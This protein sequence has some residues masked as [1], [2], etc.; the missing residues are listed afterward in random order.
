MSLTKVDCDYCQHS[1]Q[2]VGGEAVYP[3]RPDLHH[4]RFWRCMPCDAWVGCHKGTERPLGRLAN[5]QLRTAKVTAHVAFDELWKRTTPAGSYSRTGA[6]RWLAERLGIEVEGCHIGMFDVK[7]CQ[8]VVEI[9]KRSLG[10]TGAKEPIDTEHDA[11]PDEPSS[12]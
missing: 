8:R 1:A 2:L 11:N 6:Y 5:A 9:C 10:M 7:T 4:L 12:V 3:R